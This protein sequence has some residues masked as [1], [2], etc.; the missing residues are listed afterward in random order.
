MRS[1]AGPRVRLFC[2]GY[3]T[4][5][6]ELALIRYL[7]G[8]IWNF[9]YFPNLV[10]LS[11]F[12]G[13][14]IG[15]TFHHVVP[16]R[17]AGAV[18]QASIWLV[19]ALVAYV[20]VA[21]PS[22]PGFSTWGGDVGGDVYFTAVPR[23]AATQ[24]YVPFLVCIALIVLTFALVSQRTAKLFRA[25]AP[26]EAYTLDIAGSCAGIA[27]FMIISWL[28]IPAWAWK[29]DTP[30]VFTTDACDSQDAKQRNDRHQPI[31]CKSNSRK[32]E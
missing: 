27:S 24:S 5:F 23:Q 10:L 2:L 26:L 22:V 8:N 6:L 28:E 15:F 30:G 21:H 4:L 25:F 19:C 32:N 12:I 29:S 31:A 3:L 13:M 20:Y 18:F 7:S 9:G 17:L 16:D 1:V 11:V 14:G